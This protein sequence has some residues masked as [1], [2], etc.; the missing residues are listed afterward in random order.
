MPGPCWHCHHFAGM[1]PRYGAAAFCRSPGS[2]PHRSMPV[3]GCCSFEREPGADDDG[4]AP[5]GHGGE[6]PH[7]AALAIHTGRECP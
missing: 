3:D 6:H 2:A 5:V 7:L 4:W 1:E